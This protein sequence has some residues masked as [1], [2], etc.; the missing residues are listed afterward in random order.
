MISTSACRQWQTNRAA[1]PALQ[2]RCYTTARD[3]IQAGSRMPMLPKYS[4]DVNPNEQVLSKLMHFIQK[5][6]ARSIEGISY[7][8][9]DILSSFKP[10]ECANYISSSGFAWT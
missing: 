2:R 10:D 5:A 6:T 7:A 1:K 8:M 9:R 4:P 3:T